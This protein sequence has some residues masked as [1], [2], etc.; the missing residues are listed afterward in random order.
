MRV[1][2]EPLKGSISFGLILKVKFYNSLTDLELVAL[3]RRR[4]QILER[5]AFSELDTVVKLDLHKHV[6]VLG[7][8]FRMMKF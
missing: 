6:K 2:I 7:A 4:T 1:D 3:Y 5:L 8:S